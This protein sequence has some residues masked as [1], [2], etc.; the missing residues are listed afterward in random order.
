ME[1]RPLH[2]SEPLGQFEFFSLR[3]TGAGSPDNA[4]LISTSRIR[5]TRRRPCCSSISTRMVVPKVVNSQYVCLANTPARGLRGRPGCVHL[6]AFSLDLGGSRCLQLG[7]HR[8]A[9]GLALLQDRV[10][11]LTTVALILASEACAS[12]ASIAATECSR[13]ATSPARNSIATRW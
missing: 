13:S 7:G 8:I 11:R 4:V 3:K 10:G 5:I 6:V 1:S 12:V 2:P 9:V